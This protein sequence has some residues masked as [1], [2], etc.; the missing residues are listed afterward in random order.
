MNGCGGLQSELLNELEEFRFNLVGVMLNGGNARPLMDATEKQ[1]TT[2]RYAAVQRARMLG[3]TAARAITRDRARVPSR[4]RATKKDVEIPSQPTGINVDIQ[5]PSIY[6]WLRGLTRGRIDADTERVYRAREKLQQR[7][8]EE[9]WSPT[10]LRK[11]IL[12][13][14]LADSKADAERIARTDSQWAFNEGELREYSDTGYELTQWMATEDDALCPFCSAMDGVIV[15]I[16]DAFAPKGMQLEVE[17]LGE[18]AGREY[19]S[20]KMAWDITHPP[21]H[22]HC[23]CT[24]IPMEGTI[25]DDRIAE[26]DRTPGQLPEHGMD[27]DANNDG[28]EPQE[29]PKP[30]NQGSVSHGYVSAKLDDKELA[31]RVQKAESNVRELGK[32]DGNE[33]LEAVFDDGS[34]ITRDGDKSSVGIPVD[35]L[36][37]TKKNTVSMVHNHPSGN[38]LSVDDLKA[39]AK[40]R[41]IKEIRAVTQ[42]GRSFAMSRGTNTEKVTAA[43]LMAA[44][45][46]A[47]N[48]AYRSIPD[49]YGNFENGLQLLKKEP[50]EFM[51]WLSSES[52]KNT[53]DI[54][55]WDYR[56]E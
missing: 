23:R 9:R 15:R 21:L 6:N 40:F 18:D 43:E 17:G 41:A 11:E 7:A 13:E 52:L 22:P 14:G 37:K 35:K 47:D 12:R 3:R 8:D 36:R 16:G 48:K 55:G 1:I 26:S 32:K 56:E 46:Q 5:H 2:Y 27:D 51:R 4:G 44:I 49:K 53:A 38:A 29:Q 19:T 30:S 10:R 31:D 25:L 42:D 50:K 45:K 20:G 39:M 54:L 28:Q 34:V 24:M 33:H